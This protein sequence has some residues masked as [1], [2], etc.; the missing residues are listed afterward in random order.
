MSKPP[1][2]PFNEATC[3]DVAV[4]GVVEDVQEDTTTSP[5][6]KRG[7][8]KGT[9]VDLATLLPGGIGGRPQQSEVAA[10]ST[11]NLEKLDPIEREAVFDDSSFSS[12][13]SDAEDELDFDEMEN[14][15]L[16]DMRGNR[17]IPVGELADVIRKKMCCKKCALAEHKNYMHKFIEFTKKYDGEVKKE[18]KK[19]LFGSQMERLEWQLEHAKTTEELYQI[20]CGKNNDMSIEDS[21][22]KSFAVS[23]E[24]YGFATSLFGICERKIRSHTFRVDADEVGNRIKKNLNGNAKSKRYVLNYKA[25]A[26]MQQMGCGTSDMANLSAFLDL[27]TNAD[28]INYHI[29]SVEKVLGKEQ[30][31]K[32]EESEIEAVTLEIQENE[33][34]EEMKMHECAIPGKTHGPLPILKGSYGK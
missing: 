25:V 7:R 29:K 22:C 3:G 33:K 14:E 1:P 17:I 2:P 15:C 26:A 20:F 30:L 19:I 8:K 31:A 34:E 28:N 18:E 12:F 6:K 5:P 4:C 13:G 21:I 9:K 24:T 11:W 23:E 16:T 10:Q 27:P 32:R